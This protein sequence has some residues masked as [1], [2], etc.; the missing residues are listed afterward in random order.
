[1]N[2]TQ[3]NDNELLEDS[4]QVSLFAAASTLGIFVSV[5]NFLVM[6]TIMINHHLRKKSV[7]LL[8]NLALT[9]LLFGAA[10]APVG[11]QL[12]LNYRIR[13]LSSQASQ[14]MFKISSSDPL[15]PLAR[16]FIF[17]TS[18]HLIT[19]TFISIERACATLW[20]LR[21]LSLSPRMYLKCCLITWAAGAVYLCLV[22]VKPRVVNM[23][24]SFASLVCLFT[25]MASYLLIFIKVKRRRHQNQM[26][27]IQRSI[28]KER[29]LAVTLL[30]V[31]LTSLVS[32][33]PSIVFWVLQSFLSRDLN[34]S[35]H[36][37]FISIGINPLLDPLIY[38]CRMAEI[39]R[40]MKTLVCKCSRERPV[41]IQPT[42]A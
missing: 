13:S 10:I 7:Y 8:I 32:W 38:M 21:H 1:M 25:V 5:C 4:L 30:L 12:L 20:P 9:D 2:L 36:A 40:A 15:G 17:V 42:G 14:N 23:I 16:L 31:T 29:R 41:Y 22:M 33:L 3:M 11:C 27:S 19:L 34:S 24:A 18:T 28:Q 35:S 37:V 6:T 39:R 26:S